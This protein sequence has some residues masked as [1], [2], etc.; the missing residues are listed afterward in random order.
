MRSVG[1]IFVADLET[2]ELVRAAINE[3][4][5][6]DEDATLRANAFRIFG[7]TVS[8]V[9]KETII[10]IAGERLSDCE[11]VSFDVVLES[12][13]YRRQKAGQESFSDL[14]H[15]VGITEIEDAEQL[16]GKTATYR[17]VKVGGPDTPR[18]FSVPKP[19]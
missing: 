10:K 13:D 3:K 17:T 8:V 7:A 9:R 19:E 5:A 15:A 16:H 4:L 2:A 14:C 11:T 18:F 6:R 12:P 1:D